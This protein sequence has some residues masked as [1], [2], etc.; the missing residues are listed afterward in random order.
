VIAFL[1]FP[2]FCLLGH[3]CVS[4]ELLVTFLSQVEFPEPFAATPSCLVER[5]LEGKPIRDFLSA[6]ANTK[7]QLSQ[8][9]MHTVS[10]CK[11]TGMHF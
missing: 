9:G 3:A 10:R 7:L 11:R 8:L 2:P 4:R 1:H 6:D 5:L